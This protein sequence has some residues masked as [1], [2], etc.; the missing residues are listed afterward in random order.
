LQV[1]VLQAP[2]RKAVILDAAA[3]ANIGINIVQYTVPGARATALR[4]RPEVAVV[5]Q[6]AERTVE[7]A[8]EAARQSQNK[9][10]FY[11]LSFLSISKVYGR[12]GF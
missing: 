10:W 6:I 2:N 4:S 7:A 12:G 5:A 1:I 3:P 8:P 11:P 9:K